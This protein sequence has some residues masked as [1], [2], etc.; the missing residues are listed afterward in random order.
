MDGNGNRI[1]DN[2]LNSGGVRFVVEFLMMTK[3]EGGE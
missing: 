3:I 2:F 1:D